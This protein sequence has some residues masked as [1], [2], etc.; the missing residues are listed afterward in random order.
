[1]DRNEH[2]NTVNLVP[3]RRWDH[4]SLNQVVN[5][6]CRVGHLIRGVY[7]RID[8][9]FLPLLHGLFFLF[10]SFDWV[11]SIFRTFEAMVMFWV[12]VM[13]KC[14]TLWSV[15]LLLSAMFSSTPQIYKQNKTLD[16]IGNFNNF[17]IVSTHSLYKAI[18]CRANT[19]S[20]LGEYTK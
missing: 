19:Y 10:V 4:L 8:L 17:N 5:M 2:E 9:Q 13:Q 18:G 16:I 3:K 1:M 20:R 6:C 14:R 15:Q 7:M 11:L 12:I